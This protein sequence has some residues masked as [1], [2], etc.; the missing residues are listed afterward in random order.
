MIKY[1]LHGEEY[2]KTIQA[3][4]KRGL[5]VIEKRVRKDIERLN[6]GKRLGWSIPR[7]LKVLTD[8]VIM[9]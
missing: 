3:D 7:P 6:E 1:E 8:T 4:T 5:S 9:P 2:Y